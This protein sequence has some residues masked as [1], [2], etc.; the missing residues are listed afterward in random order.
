MHMYRSWNKGQIRNRRRKERIVGS[1]IPSS[2]VRVEGGKS[3]A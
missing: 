3:N 1:R 2:A